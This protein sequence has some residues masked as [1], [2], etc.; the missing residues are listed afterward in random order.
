MIVLCLIVVVRLNR[1]LVGEVR[2]KLS[3]VLI[4]LL[5]MFW[6]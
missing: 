1:V 6:C 5:V 4:W 2:L 3:I